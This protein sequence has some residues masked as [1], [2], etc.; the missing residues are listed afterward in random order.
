MNKLFVIFIL[1]QLYG[2]KKAEVSI[3]SI[4]EE[5]VVVESSS[6]YMKYTIFKGQHYCDKSTIKAFSGTQI[7]FNVKFDSSAIYKTVNPDNQ[8]DINK[9]YGFSE[10]IDNHLNSARFGW[11]WSKNAIH[12]YAYVYAAGERKF[13]EISTVGIGAVT[14]CNISISGNQY[15][16]SAAGKKVEMDRAVKDATVSGYWQYPYFGGDE[17]AL[18][19]TYIYILDTK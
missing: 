18:N 9:L 16:F 3:S 12:L 19:N 6:L 2:C 8:D 17:V 14:S 7:N 11:G 4:I 13:R 10:G 5:P 1:F 15:I